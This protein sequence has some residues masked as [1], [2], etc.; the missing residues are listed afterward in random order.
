M[1]CIALSLLGVPSRRLTSKAVVSGLTEAYLLIH[2]PR[3]AKKALRSPCRNFIAAICY[4]CTCGQSSTLC[5]HILFALHIVA[6]LAL[7]QQL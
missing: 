5:K 3:K 2:Q 6:E 4:G 7:V 1:T